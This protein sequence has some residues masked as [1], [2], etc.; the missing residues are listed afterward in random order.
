MDG[1][2][3]GIR[4]V[5]ATS[6]MA[7]PTAMYVM[8][9]MGAEVIKVESHTRSRG[10]QGIYADNEP[11]DQHWNRDGSFHALHRGKLAITLD[12]KVPEAVETFKELVR[13]SDVLA[14]NNRPGVMT[15][16]GLGYDELRKIKP[17][18]VYFSFSGF[19][20]TG[21]WKNYQGIG[22]MFELTA[23]VSQF[24]GYPEEGPRR[25]GQA[26]FDPPNGWMAVFAIL[27]ALH[28]RGQTGIGQHVDYSMYQLGAATVG[29]AILDSISNGRN[30][31]LMGNR[32]A[33]HAPHG[34][35]RC[36]GDDRWIA[37]GVESDGQW[38]ALCQAT[39]NAAWTQEDR[40]ADAL[41][42]W[43]HQIELDRLLGEWTRNYER[44]ELVALLR[45]VGVPAG[46]VLNP[47]DVLADPHI[48]ARGL[49]EQV[50]YP[51]ETGVGTR[52]HVG[53]PWKMSRT[54]SYIRRPAP[55]L[56]E[57]NE[58]ILKNLLGH[59]EKEI[60]KLYEVGAIGSEPVPIPSPSSRPSF[61]NDVENGILAGYDTDYKRVLGIE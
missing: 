47:K 50:T 23:G 58:S 36:Q 54:S 17:D 48:R 52:M 6:V 3:D 49:Y 8:S 14:E 29:D 27:S 60:S 35:Y 5:D 56:G 43:H 30:G 46:A 22:R 42:R 37:I 38:M 34:V 25:V 13:M 10:G 26:W 33:S 2:L 51:P 41:S 44:Q 32:H 57:H 21:P 20:Q 18:L 15:R 55:R 11:R 19:G 9:D 12:L 45:R 53:R 31:K 28:Y 1:P 40:F 16:L 61:E 7:M 39:D 59:E 4:I 24:T